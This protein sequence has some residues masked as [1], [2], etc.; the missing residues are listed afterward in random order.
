MSASREKKNR[1]AFAASGAIDPKVARAA[2]EKAKQHKTN[3]LYGSIAVIFVVVAV[4]VLLWNSNVIQSGKTALTVGDETYSAAQVQYHYYAAYNEVRSSNYFAYMGVDTG[5]SLSSQTMSDTAKSLLGVTDTDS[6]TWDKYLRDKALSNIKSSQSLLAAARAEGFTWDDAMQADY[7]NVISSVKSAAKSAGYSYKNYVK[8]MYGTLVSTGVFEDMVKDS[9]M[10]TAFQNDYL[11]KLN[12]TDEQ[13]EQYYQNNKS[14]FDVASYDYI[15]FSGTTSATKDENGNTVDPT[16]EQ[17]DAAIA[18]AR[19]SANT[20]YDRF[21][22]GESMEAIAKDYEI[23]S[24][25][26]VTDGANTGDTVSSWVFEKAE[27]AG[28]STV[29]DDGTNYYV[30]QFHSRDRQTYNSVNV[31]HILV[32]VD[33][34]SLDSKSDT[35]SEDLEKLKS[36]K[37]AEAEKILQEWKDGAATEE[38]FGAL[39][40]QYSDDSPEGGL[41]EQVY[42][43]QMVS[44]FND[45]C[46]DAARKTG[47]TD[48]VESSYGYHIMYFVGEDLPYWQV[49]VT[50]TMKNNDFSEWTESLLQDYTVTEGSGMK[51]VG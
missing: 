30:V 19:D 2:E 44:S 51:Y 4:L 23:A 42:K 34:S 47:D 31:R 38:S 21:K 20:A 35:Y 10:I 17:M 3:L 37:K 24:Y 11:D 15:R 41:Y 14:T 50:N 16:K 43:G 29:L 45:W 6:I 36:E 7:D 46:F 28:E 5:K 32:R 9:T 18:A 1:Q 49:R 40:D 13:I 26:P 22:N 39:A 12:Y 48:I 27:T 33:S 8:A 25:S